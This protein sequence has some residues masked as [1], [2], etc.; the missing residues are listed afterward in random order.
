MT[1]ARGPK[2]KPA[3]DRSVKT[4]SMIGQTFGSYK[5]LSE[6]GRGGMGVVYVAE[7]TLIGK[8][9]AVKVLRARRRRFA[10]PGCAKSSISEP[11]RTARS[12]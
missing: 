8:R 4:P 9:V 2:T 7:H 5:L 6:I 11:P 1:L 10:I 3:S 12:S